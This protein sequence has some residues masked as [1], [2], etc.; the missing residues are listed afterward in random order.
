MSASMFEQLEDRRLFHA[1]H[2][3][4]TPPLPPTTPPV[5]PPPVTTPLPHAGNT[6]LQNEHLAMLGLVPTD[7]ATNKVVASGLWSSPATWEG[8]V[9][10]GVDAM[11]WIPHGSAVTVDA[12]YR[13]SMEWIRADG[14]L[15]FLPNADTGLRVETV[16]ISPTGMLEMGTEAVPIAAGFESKVIFAD[17]G[18]LDASDV[19]KLGRGLI[20]HGMVSVYG[21]EVTS[22]VP[23]VGLGEKSKS[24]TLTLAVVPQ[25][26]RVGDRLVL[27]GADGWKN[28]DDEEFAL[29]GLSGNVVTLDKPL[30]Y[31]HLTPDDRFKMYLANVSRNV[32]FESENVSQS[33]RRGHIMFMHSDDVRVEN[34]GFYG[35]GRTDKRT[36][37]DD[38]EFL[39]D[40]TVEPK[41]GG[42]PRGRYAVHFH[43]TGLERA[44]SP[45]IIRGSA[46]VD[47]PGWGIVNHSSYLIAEDNVSFDAVGAHFATEAG[48]E[49]GAFRRNLAIKSEGSG[50]GTES[51]KDEQDFGHEGVGFWFQGAGVEVEGNIAVSQKHAGYIYFTQGL[52][53]GALG[54]AK[55]KSA[56]LADPS[57]AGGKETISVDKVPIRL[58]RGNESFG[59][60]MGFESWFHMRDSGHNGRSVVEDFTVWGIRGRGVHTPYTHNITF[61]NSTIFR[62]PKGPSDTAFSGNDVTK[63][64]RYENVTVEGWGTGISMPRNGANVVE[65]GVFNNIVNIDIRTAGDVKRT[66]DLNGN[67]DFRTPAP[68]ALRDRI[69][70]NIFLRGD[71]QP[72]HNDLTRMFNP[73]VIRLGT[74][75]LNGKQLYYREQDA[76][77]VPFPKE[78]FTV[79]GGKAKA[80]KLR[81]GPDGKLIA[82]QAAPYVPRELHNKSNAQLFSQYGLSIGGTVAPKSAVEVPG[83]NGVVGDPTVYQQKLT[84]TSDKYTNQIKAYTLQYRTGDGTRVKE[85]KPSVLKQ[86]WNLLTRTIGGATRTLLVY[87]DQINPTFTLDPRQPLVLNP[88]DLRRPLS[89]EGEIQDDSFGTMKYRTRFR[90]LHKQAQFTAPDGSKFITLTFKVRDFAKNEII[91]NVNVKV[92]PNAP[93]IREIKA[94]ALPPRVISGTLSALLGFKE[95]RG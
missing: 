92:D 76:D 61:R 60:A 70:W 15:R 89:L 7:L 50:D 45:A 3:H 86:G 93:L 30:K 24:I 43:R 65:G 13:S 81:Y 16:V 1:G 64:V 10:P 38:V 95:D 11:V 5:V 23:L 62:N 2:D 31:N 41:T 75:N 27:T 83:I 32:V 77:F 33:S 19:H 34:A 35:L 18:E 40:G 58:F 74:V 28:D 71:F 94:K 26:W 22:F 4:G 20:S 48:D 17:R 88:A 90:D 46:V 25:G 66:I 52:E 68:E 54:T 72:K 14:T 9:V 55:F 37:I 44:N 8:G 42:N 12:V 47:S 53:E 49:I 39:D 85:N 87:G 67:I 80:P 79:Q 29:V 91:V 59:N 51:R 73:D 69:A 57:I 56:N 84:L 63:N 82:P 21:S 78:E 36:P 6:T